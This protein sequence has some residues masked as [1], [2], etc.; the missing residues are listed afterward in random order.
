MQTAPVAIVKTA[1]FRIGGMMK[2]AATLIASDRFRLKPSRREGGGLCA[3]AL[4][5]TASRFYFLK[6]T[7]FVIAAAVVAKTAMAAESPKAVYVTPRKGTPYLLV[8]DCTIGLQCKALGAGDSIAAV[9]GFSFF[10]TFSTGIDLSRQ[11]AVVLKISGREIPGAL[12]RLLAVSAKVQRFN[13][14]VDLQRFHGIDAISPRNIEIVVD[15]V[16]ITKHPALEQ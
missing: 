14:I 8:H 7:L 9:E 16:E 12:N 10:S 4:T 5:A 15:G 11:H 2:Q 6:L 13:F 1:L 3:P